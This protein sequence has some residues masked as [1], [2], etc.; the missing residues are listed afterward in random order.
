MPQI[1]IIKELIII[2]SVSLII[3]SLFKKL[4]MPSIPGFLIA[5][6]II[7]PQGL[8]LI[9]ELGNIQVM[10]EIGVMLLLFTIGLEISFSKII[11]LKKL[12]LS[13][14]VFQVSLTTIFVSIILFIIGVDVKQSILF[15][16]LVSISST[17]IILKIL[18]DKN[19]LESPHGKFSLSI[20]IFQD[21]AF[22][23]LMMIIPLIS[24]GFKENYSGVITKLIASIIILVIAVFAS[25]YLMPKIMLQLA[26]LRLREAFTIGVVFLILGLSYLTES[27]GLSLAL[28]AFIAGL[29]LSETDFSHQVIADIIPLKDAFNSMFF[30]SIG[31]LLNLSYVIQF[32]YLI[33]IATIGI[34]LLKS[35]I[36]F[37]IIIFQKY[38]P[39]IGIVTGIGLAQVGEF[40]FVLSQA[41][42]RYDL[43][44]ADYYSAFLASSI[45]SM[46]L[47]PFLFQLASKYSFRIKDY[48]SPVTKKMSGD[49]LPLLK[50]HVIVGG[51]GLNGRN[52]ARVLKET[53]IN[54]IVLEL[55]SKVVKEFKAKKERINYGDITRRDIL[56]NANIKEASVIVFLISDLTSSKVGI[57]LAKELNPKIY[58]IVRTRFIDE[59]EELIKLGADEVIPEEFETSLQIFSKVLE[60]YHI[61]V[62]IIAK[63]AN[64]IRNEAYVMLRKEPSEFH[65]LSQIDK[66]LAEGLTESYFVEETNPNLN[67]NIK[68][69]NIRQ[70]TGATIIAIIRGG[71]NITNPSGSEEIKTGDIL[72]IYGNHLSVDKALDLL[73]A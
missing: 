33:L 50:N 9:N 71:K 69:L 40:S 5:G 28:G 65:P 16:I 58:C 41:G 29:I 23:P 13:V 67:K 20:S 2:F 18:S 22:V 12:F 31:L 21:L 54:Y 72:V 34:I 53:G 49:K 57:R 52:L 56:L 24:S 44:Q 19:E 63:Q 42:I 55:N 27:I 1:P 10:A 64:I 14:G 51:Y 8:S 3:I 25:R 47:T 73:S 43:I 6:I 30:V 7:G 62:N 66:I 46:L 59:V 70:L 26:N 11:E 45:A 60:K 61:P 38:P 48:E 36:I 17:A 39:R 35:L 4:N 15:G 68:E 37:L 32:P